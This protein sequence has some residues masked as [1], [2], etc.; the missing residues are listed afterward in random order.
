M[1]SILSIISKNT[2]QFRLGKGLTQEMLSERAGVTR[3]YISLL[4]GGKKMPAV[5]TLSKIANVLGIGVGD[6]FTDQGGSSKFIV[7]RKKELYTSLSK[8]TSFGYVYKPLAVEKKNKQ[9][10]PFL[11]KVGPRVDKQRHE[12]VHKGEEFNL[13]LRGRLQVTVGGES[14][15]LE[16]GDCIYLDSTAPHSFGVVEG[17]PA[18][19]MSVTVNR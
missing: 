11:I 12:F 5:S 17:E 10:D 8:D 7:I 9:M 4:E 2:K 14:F 18:Y 13:I 19:F 3:S 1:N 6:F 15:I 16:E